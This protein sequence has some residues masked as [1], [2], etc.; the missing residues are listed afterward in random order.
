MRS[1]AILAIRRGASS[2]QIHLA[3]VGQQRRLRGSGK[4]KL[5]QG[6]VGRVSQTSCTA[7]QFPPSRW[8]GRLQPATHRR[9]VVQVLCTEFP[10]QVLLFSQYDNIVDKGHGADERGQQPHAVDP[11]RDT[12]LEQRERQI[13]RIATA[14]IGARAHDRGGGTIARHGRASGPKRPHSVE[15][16]SDGDK[17]CSPRVA[18]SRHETRAEPA[19]RNAA[20]GPG[21]SHS[22]ITK[23]VV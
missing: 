11:D 6:G 2:L 22:G 19:M 3:Y 8:L 10:L 14:T 20:T 21:R 12:K 23:E 7:L 13:D 1:D 9:L 5:L 15:E 18:R 17:H 4:A 16:Q